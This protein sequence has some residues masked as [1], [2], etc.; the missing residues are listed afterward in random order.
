MHCGYRFFS[1]L[2]LI[3][4]LTSPIPM[5]AST[6]GQN[7]K[8]HEN[9]QAENNKRYYDKNHKDYHTWD[10][11]EEQS[12]KHYQTEHHQKRVFNQLNQSQQSNYWKW[13]HNNPDK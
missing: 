6:G 2:L 8:T 13:R 11:N 12:Y 4:A 7:D 1:S 9:N 10:S 5:M 3:A